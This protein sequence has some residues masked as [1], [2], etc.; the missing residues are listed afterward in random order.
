MITPFEARHGLIVVITRRF[1]RNGERAVQMALDT[2]TTSTT[3]RN[4]V[5][6]RLGYDPAVSAERVRMTTASGVEYVPRV[7]V[8]RIDALGERRT[9]FMVVGHT[10]PPSATVDGLLGLDFLR[11]R[12][13]VLDFRNGAIVVD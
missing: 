4:S 9:S 3:V 5:L 8:E 7:C 13:V 2:G 6:L 11:G 10:L 1:G 12:R